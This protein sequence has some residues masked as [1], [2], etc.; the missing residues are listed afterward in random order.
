MRILHA[1][2][3]GNYLPGIF[4][5]MEW[6][7]QGAAELG[8]MHDV[9]LFCHDG[10][11]KE[12]KI[13]KKV[14]LPNNRLLA[15]IIL[16]FKFYWWLF[17]VVGK[18]DK[19]LVRYSPANII[20]GFFSLFWNNVYTVHHTFEE[21]ELKSMG[22]V[23]SKL[24]VL[25]EK[26]NV[27]ITLSRVSGIIAVTNEIAKYEVARSNYRQKSIIYPNGYGK[28]PSLQVSSSS[29]KDIQI[30]FVAS[31]FVGWQGLDRLIKSVHASNTS[32]FCIHLVGKIYEPERKKIEGDHRFV[33]HGVQDIIYL[34]ALYRR[35]DIGIATFGLD[36]KGMKQAC[37][38]KVREY[39]AY[40]LPVYIGHED[41]G[42]DDNFPYVQQGDAEIEEILLFAKKSKE[43][44]PEK[45][46]LS[47]ETI[48]SKSILLAKLHEELTDK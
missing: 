4:N 16:R 5:Q 24:L 23:E 42:F 20:Q 19:V 7:S 35:A 38:L 29:G 3:M 17:G 47:A 22:G 2:F 36:R 27:W 44:C 10:V 14:S 45:I 11:K 33:I 18:Y 21:D 15:Y 37:T 26:I 46:Q 6:E 40:G 12:S 39:L 1:A 9:V 32:G 41:S 25:L 28:L 43:W 31:M 34:D 8:L 48:M 30:V 13:L